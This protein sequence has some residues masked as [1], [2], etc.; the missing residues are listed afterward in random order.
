MN[1]ILKRLIS[2]LLMTALLCTCAAIQ[3]TAVTGDN[4]GL[5]LSSAFVA[6][7]SGG[8]ATAG[9][10]LEQAISKAYT[11]G[12]NDRVSFM[13]TMEESPVV[14]EMPENT[15]FT[16]FWKSS[17]G[18]RLRAAIEKMQKKA[19]EY[20]MGMEFDVTILHSYS[21]LLNGFAVEA[22]FAAL[23][24]LQKIPGVASVE[25]MYSNVSPYTQSDTLGEAAFSAD[26]EIPGEEDTAQAPAVTEQTDLSPES[27]EAEEVSVSGEMMQ[28]TAAHE[29]GYTGEGTV[30]AVLDTSF[31][32]DH[33]VFAHAPRNPKISKT[34]LE[35]IVAQGSLNATAD[36]DAL[37]LSEKI[38]F[39]FDYS[40]DFDKQDTDVYIGLNDFHGTHV[41][42][43]AVADNDRMQGVAPNAQVVFMKVF[44]DN[45]VF[46]EPG[47]IAAMED[48]VVLGVDVLNLS[49]GENGGHTYG[50]Y[51][52]DVLQNC[53]KAGIQVVAA[54]GNSSN[55]MKGSDMTSGTLGLALPLAS[56]PDS[57][58]VGLP[59]TTG[60]VMS[61]A[62]IDRDYIAK[63]YYF[64]L[65]DAATEFHDAH[66]YDDLCFA[67]NLD[68]QTLE[69]VMIPNYG[70]AD[71]FSQVDVEG[72]IAVVY[73]G[74]I[75]ISDKEKNAEAAGAAAMIL[76]NTDD[77]YKSF[78]LANRIPHVTVK[79]SVGEILATSESKVLKID[80]DYYTESESVNGGYAS[81]FSSMGV[82][83][84]MTL[85]PEVAA[86]GG[87]EFSAVPGNSY[88]IQSGTSQASPQIAGSY[89]VLLQYYSENA[90]QLS[91]AERIDRIHT[92]QLNT[93]KILCD[94]HGVPYSPRKQGSGLVQIMDVI[95]AKAYV[96]AEDNMWP[97][98][99]LGSS[100]EGTF[101]TSFT[102][103]NV[104]DDT[105]TYDLSAVPMVPKTQIVTKDGKEYVCMS[106]YN[107]VLTEDEFRIRFS[108]D[109]V[110][111]PAG[112]SVTVD[113][114]LEL[115]E[116]GKAGLTQFENGIY[117]E[118]YLILS[119]E[120]GQQLHMPYMG[121]YGDWAALNM[122]DDTIYDEAPASF[123]GTNIAANRYNSQNNV[124]EMI[125]LGVNV[126]DT[127]IP[128][129]KNKIAM[130][131]GLL[132]AGYRPVAKMGMLR[133]SDYLS[134]R[135][136][137]SA[138]NV[139]ELYDAVNFNPLGTEMAYLYASKACISPN[140]T[141]PVP[142]ELPDLIGWAPVYE[143]QG[144]LY[145]LAAGEYTMRIA[146]QPGGTED[147]AYNQVLELPFVLDYQMPE[148]KQY[149]VLN[150][151]GRKYL[152]MQVTDDN[153]LMA[154]QL[155]STDG[156]AGYSSV[157]PLNEE[158]RGATSSILIDVTDLI[159]SDITQTAVYL[160]D[161]AQNEIS[162][163]E[164]DLT[165]EAEPFGKISVAQDTFVCHGET[166]IRLEAWVESA[167]A[168]EGITAWI[169]GDP[170]IAEVV[171]AGE[172]DGGSVAGPRCFYADVL[173]KA[174]TGQTTVTVVS[175]SGLTATVSIT[176]NAASL[177]LTK[178]KELVQNAKSLD[179]NAYTMA[180]WNDLQAALQ[181]AEAVL[182]DPQAEQTSVDTAAL[183][184]SEAIS[185]LILAGDSSVLRILIT[186]A[187]NELAEY[188]Q[189]SAQIITK[190]IEEGKAL[191]TAREV[192][193]LLD[194]AVKALENALRDGVKEDAE[195]EQ[196]ETT[197]TV[198]PTEPQEPGRPETGDHSNLALYIGIAVLSMFALVLAI[199]LLTKPRKRK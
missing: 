22:P 83:P 175:E 124:F 85:K 24:Q 7:A 75:N 111:V 106:D 12:P 126:F 174:V 144:Q 43:S 193:T 16:S 17:A 29:L 165:T 95:R 130:G 45:G 104:S 168:D 49:F 187:E 71:D 128:A 113:V 181:A 51:Y 184:L 74:E 57:G 196:P 194:E 42:G 44:G 148:L 46:N 56:E 132:T 66:M 3:V 136:L 131:N 36:P 62:S 176:A 157:I 1:R 188:T 109:T 190:R 171:A 161:Y 108:K 58:I 65:N 107:R 53:Y 15:T 134:F 141:V 96:E 90:P 13:V 101:A 27:E 140:N 30:V 105:V 177:D 35:Q 40:S 116:L 114:Q 182:S 147:P 91:A 180:S 60:S 50:G 23:E 6:E 21:V 172:T 170:S 138:G 82:C 133:G 8:Y 149:S 48:C 33:E 93:A 197:P 69:Y 78:L 169:S 158:E 47:A 52:H 185:G 31:D 81:D 59:G 121:F 156:T 195:T 102:V 178:L 72:K 28:S 87:N 77:T 139:L 125:K 97:I 86:P 92:L 183:R 73:R 110:T 179:E 80:A 154:V 159:Q 119:A 167:V 117:M 41:A 20:M 142:I 39:A 152:Q 123:Y 9:N 26:G 192:Q 198:K 54:A 164:V 112:S 118:G 38:P 70:R 189:E 150:A 84:D 160:C 76:I 162:G 19:M 37:Y 145:Y 137:D 135:V 100:D 186:K 25:V 63:T 14:E 191:I 61:V 18:S 151:G 146:A 4:I 79:K 89:A 129:D 103:H 2:V 153:Y 99:Q 122:F 10:L 67:Q 34:Y 64:L 143:D 127:T 32:V 199:I 88:Q 55:S 163:I 5:D 94:E 115:T 98:A 155:Q 11:F 173:V 120:D 68:G 166:N